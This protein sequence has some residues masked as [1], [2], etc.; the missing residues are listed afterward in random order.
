MENTLM[1]LMLR[2]EHLDIWNALIISEDRNHT[3]IICHLLL[4]PTK[5]RGNSFAG[6]MYVYLLFVCLHVT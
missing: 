3:L 6:R 1:L 2:A 5:H 4:S